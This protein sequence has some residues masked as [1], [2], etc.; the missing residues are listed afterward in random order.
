[1]Y[2]ATCHLAVEKWICAQCTGNEKAAELVTTSVTQ[3][4]LVQQ[5]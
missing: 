5:F 4:G 2:G 1:M 3:E